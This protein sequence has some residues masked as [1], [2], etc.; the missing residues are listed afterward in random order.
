MTDKQKAEQIV[1]NQ[2]QWIAEFIERSNL[3]KEDRNQIRFKMYDVCCE[4]AEWKEKEM[5]DCAV[6][7]YC[8][9]CDTKECEDYDCGECDWK[10]KF[11]KKLLKN[12]K[13]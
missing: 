8:E 9:C 5:L 10:L 2:W 12:L 4:M 11:E 13:K 3:S 6:D 1:N 7:A